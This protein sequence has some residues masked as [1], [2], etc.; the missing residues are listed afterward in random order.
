MLGIEGCLVRG[1]ASKCVFYSILFTYSTLYC[2]YNIRASTV[3]LEEH[4][5][6]VAIKR[7]D[8]RRGVKSEVGSGKL[9]ACGN[10]SMARSHPVLARLRAQREAPLITPI[11]TRCTNYITGALVLFI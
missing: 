11:K 4:A 9:R 1:V 6:D 5:V 7:L 2:I 3:D 8:F 10:E